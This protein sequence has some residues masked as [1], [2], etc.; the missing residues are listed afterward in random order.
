MALLR[1]TST[2]HCYAVPRSVGEYQHL[3]AGAAMTAA[4]A[5]APLTVLHAPPPTM[6]VVRTARGDQ[7]RAPVAAAGLDATCPALGARPPR[8]HTN[9]RSYTCLPLVSKDEA[10]PE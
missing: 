4:A 6:A 2:H 1:P 5:V 3:C 9:S 7:K 8:V 10:M